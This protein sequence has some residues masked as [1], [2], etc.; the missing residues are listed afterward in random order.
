MVSFRVILTLFDALEV[1]WSVTGLS[2]VSQYLYISFFLSKLIVLPVCLWTAKDVLKNSSST[3]EF[4]G[5]V[6]QK[7][8]KL[9]A[10]VTLKFLS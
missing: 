1:L 10:N 8:T 7:V 3:K 6:L 9:L 5:P 4:H 2:W